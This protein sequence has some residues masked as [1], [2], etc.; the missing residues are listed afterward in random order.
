MGSSG[1]APAVGPLRIRGAPWEGEPGPQTG[2]TLGQTPGAP[3]G[4]VCVWGG[5]WGQG[6]GSGHK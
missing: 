5:G 6:P 4:Y 1:S 2:S 3:L